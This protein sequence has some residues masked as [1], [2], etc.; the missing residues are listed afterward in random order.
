MDIRVLLTGIRFGTARII[1]FVAFSWHA[2][3]VPFDARIEFT[4][5]D[6]ELH[7]IIVALRLIYVLQINLNGVFR[8]VWRCDRA[9]YHECECDDGWMRGEVMKIGFELVGEVKKTKVEADEE[10]R[11]E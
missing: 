7:F 5:I 6:A 11:L 8:A 10:C 2:K 9:S 3:D 4:Q 1:F